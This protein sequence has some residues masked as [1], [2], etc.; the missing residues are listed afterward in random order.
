MN[1]IE[2]I[3]NKN[4]DEI[5]APEF[6]ATILHTSF[7]LEPLIRHAKTLLP[8]FKRPTTSKLTSNYQFFCLSEVSHAEWVGLW[9][10]IA[11]QIADHINQSGLIES[12][13]KKIDF[14]DLYLTQ[15]DESP[16]GVGPHMDTNCRLVVATLVL[17]GN[18]AFYICKDKKMNGSQLIEAKVGD[19]FLLR[20]DD[21]PGVGISTLD[22]P[23][24]YV[25]EIKGGPM[26]QF[27]MRQ[28]FT[29]PPEADYF[30]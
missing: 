29:P 3:K 18:P 13:R 30:D 22:R 12:C 23:I 1:K 28:Y 2:K 9:G 27:G 20:A 16:I 15:Y 8:R 26:L 17:E 5:H 25:G 24:H 7:D 4:H 21:F 6:G 11:G 14:D 19:I 10:K